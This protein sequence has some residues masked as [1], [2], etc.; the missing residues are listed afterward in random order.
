MRSDSECY[1]LGIMINT[2][3]EGLFNGNTVRIRLK[4]ESTSKNILIGS[5]ASRKK[6]SVSLKTSLVMAQQP[7][8]VLEPGG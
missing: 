5:L 1:H 4:S 3:R 2:L 7:A 8:G 6:S